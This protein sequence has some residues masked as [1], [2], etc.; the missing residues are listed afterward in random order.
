MDRNYYNVNQLMFDRIFQSIA[1]FLGLYYVNRIL[2]MH[3]NY[4]CLVIG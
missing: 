1:F 2:T 3:T 4:P